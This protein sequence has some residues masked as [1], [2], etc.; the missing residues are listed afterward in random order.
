M[1][2]RGSVN[3]SIDLPLASS[4]FRINAVRSFSS[5]LD[6]G[7]VITATFQYSASSVSRQQYLAGTRHTLHIE[8][9]GKGETLTALVQY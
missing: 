2:F 1:F 5:I 8:I 4:F 9:E 6:E 7:V 3:T